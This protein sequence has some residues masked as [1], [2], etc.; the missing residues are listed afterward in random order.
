MKTEDLKKL[1]GENATDETINAIMK[2]HGQDVEAHKTKVTDLTTQL[3]AANKQIGEA[4]TTIE[5]LKA[6]KPDELKAAADDYKAKFEQA[7]A[8]AKAQL[9]AVKFDHALESALT[10]AKAKNVKA[11]RALLK[12]DALKLTEDGKILGLDEQLT[13]IKK[14]ADYLF[15]GE[16]KDPKLVI[17][18]NNKPVTGDPMVAAMRK[19][20]GLP[21]PEE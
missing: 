12:S 6:M 15:E 14:D 10:G 20:A 19:A 11:V 5:G 16:K 1:L 2:L 8:D 7:Q 17:P 21:T 18:T 13:E 3:E 9:E 4:N